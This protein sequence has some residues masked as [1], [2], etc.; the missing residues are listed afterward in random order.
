[1]ELPEAS[2]EANKAEDP[3]KEELWLVIKSVGFWMDFFSSKHFFFIWLDYEF[4][5]EVHSSYL[6]YY[7]YDNCYYSKDQTFVDPAARE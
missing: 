4:T 6:L 3:G 7:D 1:M 5:S 2:P